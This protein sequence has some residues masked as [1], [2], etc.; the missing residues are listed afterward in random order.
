[1]GTFSAQKAGAQA[2]DPPAQAISD[3]TLEISDGTLGTVADEDDPIT[4]K[5]TLGRD[6]ASAA[7]EI[8]IGIL[9]LG[10]IPG[11]ATAM[12][13]GLEEAISLSLTAGADFVS[14]EDTWDVAYFTVEDQD[15]DT[16]GYQ[17]L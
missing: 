11:S 4:V 2:G 7:E 13:P 10:T 17:G 6:V 8:A 12:G 3:V 1:M 5:F 15:T 14:G 16:D 9:G